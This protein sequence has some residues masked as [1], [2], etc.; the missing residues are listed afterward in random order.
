MADENIKIKSLY[1]SL[2]VLECFSVQ[3]P[4]LGV[5]EI[6]NL[7]GIYKSNVHNILST[8]EYAGYINK[9]PLTSK[10][11]LSNKMLEYSYIVTSQLNYQ[12]V[13]YQVMK[14]ISDNINEIAYFG[15]PH[16][17]YV[18]YM[19]NTYP[20]A[21][22]ENYPIRSIMGEKAPL[23]CTS[24]GKAMLSTM[25]DEEVLDRIDMERIKYTPDTL[26]DQSDILKDIETISKRGYAID[27]IEHE[28][29]IKCVGVPVWDRNHHLLGGLSVS[30]IVR[31]FTDEKIEYYSKI[32]MD[33]A[34]EIRS[35]L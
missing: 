18:L 22:D 3:T 34:F 35:K 17:K 9:N 13:V 27:N 1:K 5:T 6:S 20:K 24:I 7:L 11:F 30:G 25:T 16:G 31:N 28:L 8:L 29:G 33:A 12:N 23:Y 4:E 32:L 15:I 14:R 19:F 26:V 21:Y 2:E 10:Y